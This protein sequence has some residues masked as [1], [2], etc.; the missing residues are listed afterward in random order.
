MPV[1][2]TMPAD[3][4]LW[5][6]ASSEP[7]TDTEVSE[8]DQE[9]QHF[10][11]HWESHHQAL[12]AEAAIFYNHFIVICI[13]ENENSAGGCSV[14]K[15]VHLIKGF[16]QK[17]GKRLLDRMLIHCIDNQTEQIHTFSI[18][19]FKNQYQK[20]AIK[21]DCLMFNPIIQNLTDFRTK[22][23]QSISEHWIFKQLENSVNTY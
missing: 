14:D 10:V 18:A 13:D 15:S 12:R 6:Y 8:L 1:F 3:S 21:K 5:V 4:R 17:T 20:G 9:L 11:Q 2:D 7:F 16:E 23:K 22:W 19:E